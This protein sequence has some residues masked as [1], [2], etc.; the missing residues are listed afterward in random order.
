MIREIFYRNTVR[1]RRD[2]TLEEDE[3]LKQNAHKYTVVQLMERTGASRTQIEH[4]CKH[5]C[6]VPIR[7]HRRSWTVS[8]IQFLQRF[9]HT[10]TMSELL[11]FLPHGVKSIRKMCEQIGVSP[12]NY[13]KKNFADR[14]VENSLPIE[15]VEFVK[16]KFNPEIS[17][18]KEAITTSTKTMPK[19]KAPTLEELEDIKQKIKSYRGKITEDQYKQAA[20]MFRTGEPR[21]ALRYCE[22]VFLQ[23]KV[24][25][26][27]HLKLQ[28]NR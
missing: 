14:A 23:N 9:A 4:R 21:S 26:S 13:F 15:T 2:W 25:I 18:T 11:E 12:K 28:R 27:P 16:Q 6:L 3:F 10:K 19:S 5:L 1:S 7:R 20:S 8:E 17:E 22:L 24:S